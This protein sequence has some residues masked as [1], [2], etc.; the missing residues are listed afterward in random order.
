MNTSR[1]VTIGVLTG[2]D[3]TEAEAQ[4]LREWVCGDYLPNL[5]P[6]QQ[7]GVVRVVT[8]LLPGRDDKL[9][10][11]ILATARGLQLDTELIYLVPFPWGDFDDAEE[12]LRLAEP[13]ENAAQAERR[14]TGEFAGRALAARWLIHLHRFRPGASDDP[15]LRASLEQRLALYLVERS[16]LLVVASGDSAMSR[17][18]LAFRAAPQDIDP[19]LS[20]LPPNPNFQR[21]VSHHALHFDAA[22]GQAVETPA[23]G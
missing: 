1:R 4:A 22:S 16:D 23:D 15:E 8:G 18:A 19:A 10:H 20:T 2:P 9:C 21:T 7:P 12:Y 11:D 5:C 3:S 14:L 17:E 13:G 6:R